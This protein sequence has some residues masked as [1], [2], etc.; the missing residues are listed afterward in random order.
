[1]HRCF[2]SDINRAVGSGRYRICI[3]FLRSVSLLPRVSHVEGRWRKRRCM[4][5]PVRVQRQ[6][7]AAG[8]GFGRVQ[9]VLPPFA[10]RY[11]NNASVFYTQY[12]GKCFFNGIHY[13]QR[14][15]SHEQEREQIRYAYRNISCTLLC[16][17]HWVPFIPDSRDGAIDL[18]VRGSWCSRGSGTSTGF[19]GCGWTMRRSWKWGEGVG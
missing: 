2:H 1:M 17:V 13:S 9:E 15:Q 8:F 3:S 5:H 16:I 7:I 19:D 6:F 11:C 18:T 10:L 14:E 4:L 12:R